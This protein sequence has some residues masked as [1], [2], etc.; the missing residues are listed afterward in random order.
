VNQ[1]LFVNYIKAFTFN[2]VFETHFEIN[3]S[4]VHIYL[5]RYKTME[6]PENIIYRN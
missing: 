4:F 3:I 6:V 5:G 1:L 2:S